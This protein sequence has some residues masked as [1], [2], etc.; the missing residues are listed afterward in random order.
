MSATYFTKCNEILFIYTIKIVNTDKITEK[1]YIANPK[2]RKKEN[3]NTRL[4]QKKL[5]NKH[6]VEIVY[7]VDV[8]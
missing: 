3:R 4:V 6:H 2:T 8:H 7:K 1:G 5:Q